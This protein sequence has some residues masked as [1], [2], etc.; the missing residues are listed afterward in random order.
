MIT[1]LGRQCILEFSLILAPKRRNLA[2]TL[3]C[4]FLV[5]W[6]P[7]G[8]SFANTPIKLP[9]REGTKCSLSAG[10]FSNPQ[11][12]VNLTMWANGSDSGVLLIRQGPAGDREGV[13]IANLSAGV[14]T[15]PAN[16]S[17]RLSNGI[18]TLEIKTNQIGFLDSIAR[19]R[20]FSIQP[21]NAEDRR[22]Y[23]ADPTFFSSAPTIQMNLPDLTEVVQKI[24]E[25]KA[26][27]ERL[28]MV[29]YCSSQDAFKAKTN[30]CMISEWRVVAGY[31]DELNWVDTL[32][33]ERERNTV[34]FWLQTNY[35][36]IRNK[37]IRT[38]KLLEGRCSDY[39]VT[40]LTAASFN[41]QDNLVESS[42]EREVA[43]APKGSPAYD[44][45]KAV[46]TNAWK[47]PPQK[48]RQSS[49]AW[50]EKQ[51]VRKEEIKRYGRSF[52]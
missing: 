27:I 45:I 10:S 52:D 29:D 37:A 12:A 3:L 40:L 5:V 42:D 26:S 11:G 25:C 36:D 9:V 31:D 48:P 1:Q 17:R 16:F 35:P 51:R 49:S 41:R 39:S 50:F 4:V 20:R 23:G 34:R 21:L 38:I 32:S 14:R 13:G 44:S 47:S 46:C 30:G 8:T 24:N 19:G 43:Q 15:L 6:T 28:V 18:D 22:R 2:Q 33:I 7:G